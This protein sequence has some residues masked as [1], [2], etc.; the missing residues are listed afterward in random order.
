VDVPILAGFGKHGGTQLFVLLIT[1]RVDSLRTS[2]V[3]SQLAD[4]EFLKKIGNGGAAYADKCIF[5]S[6][7]RSIAAAR[8]IVEVGYAAG[9]EAAQDT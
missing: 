9:R 7:P 6:Q 3:R 8:W 4:E 5:K 2:G 1:L